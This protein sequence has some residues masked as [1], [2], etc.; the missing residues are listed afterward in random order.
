MDSLIYLFQGFATAVEPSNLLFAAIGVLTVIP[1]S[2]FAWRVRD[3][4]RAL[5]GH[6][7][8]AL[9]SALILSAAAEV[10]L[11]SR[12]RSVPSPAS[13]LR[14]ASSALLFLALL[15]GLG[16]ILLAVPR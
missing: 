5:F 6:A 1:L 10:A 14:R 8:A 16:A 15:I 11:G 3:V 7:V 13:R 9:A 12:Q 2:Y 4:P